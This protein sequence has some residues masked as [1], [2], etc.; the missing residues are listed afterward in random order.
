MFRRRLDVIYYRKI[1][2]SPRK[3]I[4]RRAQT[5][6]CVG[7]YLACWQAGKLTSCLADWLIGLAGL[8]TV[9]FVALLLQLLC[10]SFG[11]E[12]VTQVSCESEIP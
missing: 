8:F 6:V 11:K 2:T 4:E 5:F 1:I 12:L 10:F 7:G 9:L 3:K